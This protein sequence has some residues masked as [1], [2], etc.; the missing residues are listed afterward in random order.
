MPPATLRRAA[1]AVSALLSVTGC[2]RQEGAPTATPTI[3]APATTPPPAASP[4]APSPSGP[5]DEPALQ[6]IGDFNRPVHVT[7]P[8][9]DRRLF[10]VEKA[11]K[12]KVLSGGSEKTFLDL[13]GRVALG[14]EQGLLSLA[15]DPGYRTSG[16]AYVNYT[17]ERGDTRIVEYRASSDADRLDPDTRREI[18]SVDQ[19]FQNHNGGLLLF[20][21]SGKMLIGMGDGG[22]GGDPADRAQNLRQLLGKL[23]RIEPSKPSGG[24]PYS[25]PP[26]NPFV[27][28]EEAR[29]EIWA[30]GLR[31]P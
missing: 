29:G 18:L 3:P 20:D 21:P 16:R 23:L 14:Y 15:F 7:A 9:G 8:Q 10:V 4:A 12:V 27:G 26:D 28:R 31:N 22:S 5:P 11:G 6:K 24:A 30:Y 17:D 25:V 19:P 1:F 13:S 2:G